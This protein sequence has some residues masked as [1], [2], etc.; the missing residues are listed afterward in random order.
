MFTKLYTTV[1]LLLSISGVVYYAYNHYVDLKSQ[2]ELKTLES[3]R[4]KESLKD[5]ENTISTL[6][7]QNVRIQNETLKL[8]KSLQKA[9]VY[10]T[11]LQRKLNDHNLTKLSSKKPGL[12]EKRINDATS[13]IF[14]ELEE[15]TSSDNT[16][17][18]IIK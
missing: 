6:T 17:R 13:K 10:N 7:E 9:E 16:N 2:L 18:S 15:I 14:R 3:L 1:I 11:E 4:F 8:Q 5:N 12:I